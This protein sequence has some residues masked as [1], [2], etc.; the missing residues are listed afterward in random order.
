MSHNRDGHGD[1]APSGP[2]PD[3]LAC[4]PDDILLHIFEIVGRVSKSDLCHVSRLNKRF[5]VLADS[6]LYKTVHFDTPEHHL[7]F[8]QSLARRPRRGSL[9]VGVRLEYP[10]SE[11]SHLRLDAPVHGSHY[12]PSLFDGLSRAISTMSNLEMLDISVPDTLLHGIGTLFNGPFD[13]AYLKTCTLFYQCPD[14]QYWDLQ[15]NI[16]IFAHP[17]LETLIIKRAKLDHRGF[18]FIEQ[19]HQTALKKLHLIE[20]DIN[21]DALS[22]I[23][24]FP[25]ALKEFVMTQVPEPVPELVDSSDNI[26]DYIC[27]LS[28]A[29]HSLQSI[30]IDFPSLSG[31]KAL[32]MRDF[33][34]LKT[35]RVN[36]DYQLF[37]KSSKKPRMH[38]VG[39]P[40]ELETLE[41]FNELGT[42]EGVTDLLLYAIQNKGVTA[43]N[44]KTMI[45]VEGDEPS[46]SWE[47]KEAC[48]SQELELRIIGQL[49]E[50]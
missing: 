49:D 35:L 7:T 4:L 10:E 25:E 23:L 45:V 42:D 33:V 22:D 26:A 3:Q 40:P 2:H 12:A 13:L 17:T 47:L 30:L 6:L 36:W 24:E 38:S 29:S 8:S 14:D 41:F 9:I 19:P 43:R 37:G 11:L 48:K 20:C 46:L 44:L 15:E 28:S 21:D 16:H 32:R 31:F 1:D 39:L 18:D 5:H 27:A 50:E 34:A